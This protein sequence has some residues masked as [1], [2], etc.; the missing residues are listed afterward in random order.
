MQVVL[1]R[2]EIKIT[3]LLPL[4]IDI[5]LLLKPVNRNLMKII[6]KI[7]LVYLKLMQDRYKHENTA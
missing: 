1:F 5:L 6:K 4:L 3:M 2:E 7:G